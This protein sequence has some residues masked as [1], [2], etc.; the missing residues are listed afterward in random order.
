MTIPISGFNFILYSY[1]P[2]TMHSGS[3]QT[4]GLKLQWKQP[5]TTTC[6]TRHEHKPKPHNKCTRCAAKLIAQAK[7]IPDPR[8]HTP[9]QYSKIWPILLI[10]SSLCRTTWPLVGCTPP[11]PANTNYWWPTVHAK[12][13]Q[14]NIIYTK[15][16]YYL[17]SLPDGLFV[18]PPLVWWMPM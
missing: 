15:P 18:M 10:P 9:W 17:L 5:S 11:S 16:G 6:H 7:S 8:T 12:S 1:H 2:H 3:T 13:L 14:P 4:L